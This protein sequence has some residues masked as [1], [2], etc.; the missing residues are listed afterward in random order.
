M[1][2]WPFLRELLIGP[3]GAA[4]AAWTV[5]ALVLARLRRTWPLAIFLLL[6]ATFLAL[7]A[8]QAF[9]I[10]GQPSPDI[11]APY[12][13][14]GLFVVGS[15]GAMLCA[16]FAALLWVRERR[17]ASAVRSAASQG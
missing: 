12:M 7:L 5:G 3:L 6:T 2:I 13:M 14:D 11:A 17:D 16:M 4:L 1:H 9:Q 15:F 10:S 8:W